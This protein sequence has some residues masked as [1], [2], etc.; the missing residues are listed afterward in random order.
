MRAQTISPTWIIPVTWESLP[1]IS[2]MRTVNDPTRA[3]PRSK[4]AWNEMSPCA[5]K[6]PRFAP[7]FVAMV[8]S[9]I[10]VLPAL[11][12]RYS[13]GMHTTGR[14]IARHS[15]LSPALAVGKVVVARDSSHELA[16][17]QV[18]VVLFSFRHK[19]SALPPWRQVHRACMRIP[20]Q[21]TEAPMANAGW[22]RAAP[23][24]S[25]CAAA[26]LTQ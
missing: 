20:Q 26:P 13:A 24:Q 19:H 25:G 4:V 16:R 23:T 17:G 5:D 10:V 2:L 22:S 14:S 11:R 15:L 7:R 8:S 1:L 21:P 9:R 12:V 6:R 18:E 3:V